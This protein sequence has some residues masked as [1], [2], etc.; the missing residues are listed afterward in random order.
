MNL[1]KKYG[2]Q[3]FVPLLPLI[4]ILTPSQLEKNQQYF[5][6]IFS[7]VVFNWLFSK[8]PL[9]V[10]GFLGVI[11]ASIINLAPVTEIFQNFG[12]PIIF[13]F[14]GGFLLAKA[15]NNVGLDKRISLYLLTR[16]FIKG[17]INR[18]LFSLMFLTAT[19]TMWISNT[20][21]TAMMLPLVLGTL[22]SLKINDK[23]IISLILICIAY[24][25]SIGGIATPIGSTPNIIAIGMLSEFVQVKI[26]FL[27]W[28]LYALPLATIF[29]FI[30]YGL[31]ILQIR[32]IN[33]KIDNEF[34]VQEY[35]KLPTL[36][37]YEVYTFFI[38]IGTVFLW[39]LPSLLKLADIKLPVNLNSGVVAMLGASL[40]FIFPLRSGRKILKSQDISS[41]DWSSLMLFGT[42]L[43]LGKLLFDLGLAKI[44]G[45]MLLSF[46]QDFGLL[47]IFLTVFTFVIFST[48]LTSNTASANIILPIMISLAGQLNIS[49]IFMAMGVAIACSLAFMLPVA[50][51]PN[52]IVFGSQQVSKNQMISLGLGLNIIFSILLS[53]AI[54]TY[55]TF[56]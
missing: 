49:P 4:I 24:S 32:K 36:S 44:A 39:I 5:L 35:K 7:F 11:F 2:V 22:A 53:I 25:S 46:I 28:M 43:A 48:E 18:L 23:K 27:E 29:L 20:A 56:A 41:I 45:A 40:L 34:L 30:L 9:Y 47:G 10:T 26:S 31:S 15:F 12:H 33:F 21:T 54:Y 6:A 17:S 50:T 38:F 55:S 3:V 37:N 52:A 16:P 1:I 8:I 42:G 13:L 19:F 14:L 51:P